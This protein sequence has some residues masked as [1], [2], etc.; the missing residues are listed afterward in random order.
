MSHR[1]WLGV[2]LPLLVVLA[3]CGT[4]GG[5]SSSG[6]AVSPAAP[7]ADW[8]QLAPSTA[9]LARNSA[10]TAFDAANGTMVVSGGRH[11]CALTSAI[12]SDTWSWNGTTW[13]QEQP[14]DKGPAERIIGAP[15][16]YDPQSKAVVVV[17]YS[18]SCGMGTITWQWNGSNWSEKDNDITG[19]PSVGSMAYDASSSK[20]IFWS[21]QPANN[22]DGSVQPDGSSTWSWDGTTWSQLHPA[23]NPP[24][25]LG[26]TR[27][28]YDPASK[29]CVLYDTYT[30]QMWTWDGS[31]WSQHSQSGGPS[32][33]IG[34]S[35]V[36]DD[37]IGKT[38]LFGGAAVSGYKTDSNGFAQ[39][40]FDHALGDMWTWDGGA[41]TQLHPSTAP[42]PRY[43]AQMVYDLAHNQLVLFGGAAN[44]TVDTNDTWVFGN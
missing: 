8:R 24:A 6:G 22:P 5:S 26:S 29:L 25:T 35:M 28:V 33:R 27:M 20:V 42:S 19:P 32:A 10:G 30:Q 38:V 40:T 31:N 34:A 2:A 1:S 11:G 44:E 41:W 13:K 17:T 3:G 15:V 39:Y 37:A 21:S 36:Y 43:D 18:G 23:T 9:P 12:Y 14:T 16:A 4:S 7:V